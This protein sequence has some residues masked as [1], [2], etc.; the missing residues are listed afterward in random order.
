M[1]RPLDT[2]KEHLRI[3]LRRAHTISSDT[4]IGTI[5]IGAADLNAMSKEDEGVPYLTY[6]ILDTI[7]R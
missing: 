7:E 1:P 5:E 2:E 4:S 3:I 6:T